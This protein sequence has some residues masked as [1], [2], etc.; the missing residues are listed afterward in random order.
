MFTRLTEANEFEM[1]NTDDDDGGGESAPQ[2]P[3]QTE[4]GRMGNDE[5]AR[6]C[7]DRRGQKRQAEKAKV[8][9]NFPAKKVFHL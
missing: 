1:N 9:C 7:A 6:L 5:K 2:Y 8:L 4:K 3:L